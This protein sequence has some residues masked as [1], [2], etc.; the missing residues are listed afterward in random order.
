M[1]TVA[2]AVIVLAMAALAGCGSGEKKSDEAPGAD[3]TATQ[4]ETI[5]PDTTLFGG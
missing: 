3:T 5:S 2:V 4:P 1:R